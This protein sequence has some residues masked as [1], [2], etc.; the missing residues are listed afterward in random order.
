[1]PSIHNYPTV[2]LGDICDIKQGTILTKKNMINGDYDVIGG[3]KIIGKHNS[4]NRNSNE[5][6]ITRV[7]DLTITYMHN[8]YYLT[9]NGISIK[10]NNYNTNKLIYYLLS[11]SNL[12]NSIKNLYNGG[13][14][15]V[16]SLTKIKNILIPIPSIEIQEEVVKML[17]DLEIQKQLLVDR[18]KGIKRQMKYYMDTQIKKYNEEE[19][20]KKLGDICEIKNGNYNSNE[21]DNIGNIPFYSCISNNPAG[22]CSKYNMDYNDYLLL[23]SSGGSLKN[24]CGENVGLGKCY[25]VSGKT[26]CRT[27]VYA[28]IPKIQNNISYIYYYLNNYRNITNSKAEFTTNLGV[29][30]KNN[31]INLLIPIPSIEIQTKMVEYLDKLENKKNNIDEEINDINTL[32]KQILENSYNLG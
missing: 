8:E 6:V 15:Q 5:T 3:G 22:V 32:M 16:I 19:Y 25:K 1:M 18:K 24:L 4:S 14:Q 2:K 12:N 9:D 20:W 23:V 11:E 17:D 29:I 13:G 21:M 10:H 26:A 28:L 7:G 30:S 31:I 27:N